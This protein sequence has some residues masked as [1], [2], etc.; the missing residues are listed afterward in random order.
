MWS[1]CGLVVMLCSC[2]SGVH[3][4]NDDRS[5]HSP[6]GCHVADSS[7]V[8]PCSC[9]NTEGRRMGGEYSP[10]VNSKVRS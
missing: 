4:V 1:S 9:D 10:S 5:H 8:A 7:N 2:G 3:Q 6:F